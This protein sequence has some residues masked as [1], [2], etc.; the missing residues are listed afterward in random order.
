M[1]GSIGEKLLVARK[2]AGLSTRAVVEKLK[3]VFAV[4]H[5]TIANYEKGRSLPNIAVLSV[6]ASIYDRPL[7]WFL[8]R[9]AT[10]TGVQYRNQPSK[11]HASD[12]HWFEAES[13]RWLEGYARLE[14][15]LGVQLRAK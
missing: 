12:K 6:L 14:R 9:G 1:Q 8:D 2:G 7:N 15:H 13:L 3:G 5:A 4:S 11:L 10:L